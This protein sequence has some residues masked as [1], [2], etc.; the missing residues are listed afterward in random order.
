MN[1]HRAPRA[2][3]TSIGEY[4]RKF[5]A[6]VPDNKAFEMEFK[7]ELTKVRR[8]TDPNEY[9]QRR[10]KTKPV[11]VENL[12]EPESKPVR[13]VSVADALDDFDYEEVAAPK[14]ILEPPRPDR[15]KLVQKIREHITEHAPDSE[16]FARDFAHVVHFNNS[17]NKLSGQ[18]MKGRDRYLQR[19][20][21][22]A[23]GDKSVTVRMMNNRE[24]L[25]SSLKPHIES[26]T[27]MSNLPAGEPRFCECCDCC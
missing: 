6:H 16:T 3:F 13:E 22:Y 20:R 5:G 17:A 27:S 12:I 10:F 7:R 2:K 1:Y 21:A 9:I 19:L 15:S 23:G 8:Q 26:L 18:L 24:V 4:N 14:A 25:V 11:V